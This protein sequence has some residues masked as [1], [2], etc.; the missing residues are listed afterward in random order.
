MEQ[1]IAQFI[2]AYNRTTRPIRRIYTVEKLEK[3]LGIHL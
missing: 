3:K 2:E 1:A